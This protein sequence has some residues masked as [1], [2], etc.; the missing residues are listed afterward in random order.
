MRPTLRGSLVT[1]SQPRETNTAEVASIVPVRADPTRRGISEDAWLPTGSAVEKCRSRTSALPRVLGVWP[2]RHD[3]TE[4]PPPRTG[5][6]PTHAPTTL[7]SHPEMKTCTKLRA[8][9]LA[10]LWL[11]PKVKTKTKLQVSRHSRCAYRTT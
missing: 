2:V 4:R 8:G 7:R 3:T 1:R 10:K 6:S 11:H 5:A 9:A